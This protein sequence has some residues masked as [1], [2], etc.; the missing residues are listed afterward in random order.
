MYHLKTGRLTPGSFG[1]F[2]R[3]AIR[4][5][6][7]GVQ[8]ATGKR[9]FGQRRNFLVEPHAAMLVEKIGNLL[10]KNFAHPRPLLVFG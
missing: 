7:V 3:P 6:V 1:C 9:D 4:S 5:N 2:G 10:R 8:F